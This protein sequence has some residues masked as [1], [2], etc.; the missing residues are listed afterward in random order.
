MK[1]YFLGLAL[2]ALVAFVS[3]VAIRGLD[4][5][6]T[7]SPVYVVVGGQGKAAGCVPLAALL[8]VRQGTVASRRNLE[9][10]VFFFAFT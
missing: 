5:R 2:V 7:T 3:S 10:R 9:S 8:F 1:R 6:T 4:A